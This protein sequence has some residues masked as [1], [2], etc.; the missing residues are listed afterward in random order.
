MNLI[1]RAFWSHDEAD[2]VKRFAN[3][4]QLKAAIEIANKVISSW[5]DNPGFLERQTRKLSID[6]L[7]SD[8]KKKVKYW[9]TQ[10]QKAEHLA[11]QAE[12]ALANNN[13]DPWDTTKLERA[14]YLYDQSLSL[15]DNLDCKSNKVICQTKLQQKHE[16]Q[17][18]FK[19]GKEKSN[20]RYYKKG[21]EKFFKA[22][23][24]F[25]TKTLSKEIIN[26]R[27]NL[28]YEKQYEKAYNQAK[29]LTKKGDF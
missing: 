12:Q 15:M 7:L 8:L 16:F 22:Q 19:E 13:S 25:I 21:L 26:C 11:Q 27:E 24:L 23:F 9:E 1:E 4:K 29:Q 14:L 5:S 3:N 20:K 6:N 2:R 10:V 17:Q 28:F 18:Y